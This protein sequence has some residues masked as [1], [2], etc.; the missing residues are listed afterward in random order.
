MAGDESGA[1]SVAEEEGVQEWRR[2]VFPQRDAGRWFADTVTLA[3]SGVAAGDAAG[4][5]QSGLGF[6]VELLI[7]LQ[8]IGD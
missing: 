6:V 8:A 5:G 1:S 4:L 3:F 7:L 2:V